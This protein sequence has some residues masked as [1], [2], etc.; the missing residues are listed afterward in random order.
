LDLPHPF[1]GGR[2]YPN[3]AKQPYAAGNG[4]TDRRWGWAKQSRTL[5]YRCWGGGLD[6]GRG[7]G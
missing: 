4:N 6:A 3:R 7:G 5:A 1:V 2:G